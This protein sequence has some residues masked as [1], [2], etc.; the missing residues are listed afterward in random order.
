MSIFGVLA[1]LIGLAS[2]VPAPW[3]RPAMSVIGAGLFAGPSAVVLVAAMWGAMR[4]ARHRAERRERGRVARSDVVDLARF[5]LVGV[6][7][8]WSLDQSLRAA[9]GRLDRVVA[10][11]VDDILRRGRIEGLGSSLATAQGE[12]ATL[13]RMLARSHLGGVTLDRSL[14]AF[15][16]EAGDHRRGELIERARRLPIRMVVP[17]TLLMLPGFVLLVAGPTLLITTRRLLEPFIT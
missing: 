14:A 4:A 2:S 7:A 5:L 16:R 8:G 10:G 11:E 17:L 3:R 13:Y 6:G 15:I 9:A 12:G 1:V